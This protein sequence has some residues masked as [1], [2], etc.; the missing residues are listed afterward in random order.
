V[1]FG[2]VAVLDPGERV[3]W[4]HA[5]IEADVGSEDGHVYGWDVEVTGH[6]ITA[7]KDFMLKLHEVCGNYDTVILE[8]YRIFGGKLK[9]HA[10]SDV[11]TLQ[12]IGQVKLCCWLNPQVKLVMQAPT[13]QKPGGTG[14]KVAPPVIREILDRLPKSHDESHDGS[15]LRH[16]SFYW[17]KNYVG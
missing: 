6:G 4:C 14:D 16:L 1:I 3:G 7:W 9:E 17:F 12:A 8:S 11:P 10:G 2:I 5:N 15:A 13:A